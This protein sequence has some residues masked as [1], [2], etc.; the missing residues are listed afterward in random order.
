MLTRELERIRFV[1]Q[2]FNDLQGLR[3]A[4][5]LGL[6][7]LSW[8]GPLLLRTVLLL[9]AVLLLFGGKRYYRRTFGEVEQQ[10]ADPASELC[11]ASIFNPAGPFSRLEG[12]PQVTP[13]ARYLLIVVTLALVVF[14]F[15]QAIPPNFLV[16]GDASPGQPLRILLEPA[17]SIGPPLIKMLDGAAVRAPSMQKAVL[18]QAMYVLYGSLFLGV[19]LWRGRR[20]SQSYH[21]VLGLLLLALSALGTSLGYLARPGGGGMPRIIDLS[22]P[23]LV[24][25]GMA[26]LLCGSLMVVAGLLD[27]WQLVRALGWNAAREEST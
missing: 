24:G 20:E 9:G 23:A 3:L 17:P 12:F 6:I 5:P 21:L 7:T 2:H 13:F 26:V 15:F 11:P 18:A 25:P 8:G 19:W 14:S 22:L 16:E 10:P 1:T 4:V 27:H